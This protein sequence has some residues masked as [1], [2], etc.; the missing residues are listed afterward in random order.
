[1][2][3]LRSGNLSTRNALAWPESIFPNRSLRENER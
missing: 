2:S 1:M 3:R